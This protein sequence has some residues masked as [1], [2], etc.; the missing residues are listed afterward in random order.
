MA[1]PDL[2]KPVELNS[3]APDWTGQ[4]RGN[5]IWAV[6]TAARSGNIDELDTLI[7]RCGNTIVHAEYWYTQ[8][9]HF[10]VREG[11]LRATERLVQAGADLT[12]RSLYNSQTLLELAEDRGHQPVADYLRSQ[13]AEKLASD[14]RSHAIH[15]NVA[16]NNPRIVKELLGDQPEMA[17]RGDNLGRKPLHYAMETGSVEMV[18]LLLDHG[19]DIDATGFS[20]DDRLGGNGFRPITLALWHHPYWR[21]RNDYDMVR[22]LIKRGADYSMTIAAAMGDTERVTNLLQADPACANSQESGG[23]RPLSAASERDH[24]AI[25]RTL[26]DA[27]ADPNLQEGPMCPRGYSLWAAAHFGFRAVTQALAEA[28]ADPNAPVESSATPTES[29]LDMDMRA[30]I[31]TYGGK[32]GISAH[33]WKNHIDTIAALLDAKPDLFTSLVTTDAFT[34]AVSED[35]EA[36]VRL[37]LA[38]GLRLP[39]VV[40]GCQTYLWRSLRLARLLLQHDMD[41]NL[42]NWQ[43]IR[44][45]HHVAGQGN[46]DAARLF[47]EFGADPTPI[48]EEFRSTPL[49]WAAREGHT[50]FIQ[51]WLDHVG[52]AEPGV[53]DWAR[54]GNWAA[55]SGH[56][57][58]VKL[59]E[60]GRRAN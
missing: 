38:R 20:S 6:L 59:L 17:N 32:M 26:L 21:Q 60:A 45:L 47:L 1:T 29:A 35:N 56:D 4:W 9:L 24:L 3:D 36:M 49:G 48:D 18:D 51:W 7:A 23:K 34:Q 43:Q 13:L 53:P 57:N 10:A 19:A 58:I 41:P 33:V 52:P 31:Y 14:G 12:C 27:G 5:D 28:G 42:P 46:I 11:H 30:L 25:V 50:E 37:L 15:R 16:N 44:P 2:I 40:T 8:P 55:R 54:A 22:H 39:A